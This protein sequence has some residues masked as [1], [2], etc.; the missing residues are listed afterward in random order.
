[1]KTFF[2][3][4][5]PAVFSAIVMASRHGR[6][7]LC[8]L[9]GVF[10]KQKLLYLITAGMLLLSTCAN[11]FATEEGGKGSFVV[12]I[13]ASGN[14]RSALDYPPNGLAGAPA[15]APNLAD[16]KF[17]V[18]FTQI[19]GGTAKT[20][21][22][23]GAGNIKGTLGQGDYA[24]TTKVYLND[25]ATLYAQGC[26]I[27]NPV[28]IG[29]GTNQI[30]VWVYSVDDAAMPLI[31]AKPQGATYA[32]GDTATALTVGASSIDGGTV[33]YE[34]FTN[35]ATNSA[36]GGTS[37]GTGTSLTPSTA[38]AGTTYYYVKVTNAKGG[39]TQTIACGPVAVVVNPVYTVTFNKNNTTAGSTEANPQTKTVTYPAT[40]IDTLPPTPPTRTPFIFDGWN[41]QP[42]GSGTAFTAS[43]TVTGDIAVYAQWA[44]YVPRDI[45]WP[46]ACNAII[47]EG[48]GTAGNY[49][50]YTIYVTSDF[51]TTGVTT[52]TF[53]NVTYISVTITGSHTIQ[54]ELTGTGNLLYIGG[55]QTVTLKDA[56]LKGHSANNT[57]L[58][59]VN[60]TGATLKME[61]GEISGNTANLGGGV[62]NYGTFAMSGG[63]ISN[64]TS[65]TTNTSGDGGG[66]VLNSGTFTMSGGTISGNTA[67]N[68]GGG[69]SNYGTFNMTGGTIGP[70]N[71]ARIGSGVWVYNS[72]FTMSGG[73]I[74]GNIASNQGGGVYVA[75]G[76]TAYTPGGTLNMSGGT[77][78]GNT[79]TN[80]GGGVYVSFGNAINAGR[81]T[82]H[83]VTG[84]IYGI[85]NP[86]LSNTLSGTG[87]SAALYE[88]GSNAE[89]GTFAGTTWN[90]KGTL[91]TTNDTIKVKDGEIEP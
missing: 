22:K 17:S 30:T 68:V 58:V 91:S 12:T 87:T 71:K 43:T 4:S 69:V 9:A 56:H 36:S 35:G 54:L 51:D 64:N 2:G 37:A 90:S 20:F 18:T 55:N 82:L 21:D 47:G 8:A 89:R 25:G 11:P 65:T 33:S 50:S 46:N 80:Q 1:M 42:D 59:Y 48:S 85:D 14:S 86:S 32:V 39:N 28:H 6:R 16:L 67:V 75:G 74:S 77:I 49:K 31:S 78:S 60:G 72:I 84:A 19:P 66:G 44:L 15:D 13:G 41:T 45:S 61:S 52:Y 27:D 57:S 38:T 23:Q 63:T 5:I 81:G 29:G 34:W 3:R 76:N 40:N 53:G 73:E 83:M 79:A 70:G 24:V 7:C 10:A 62:L 88:P 26:A